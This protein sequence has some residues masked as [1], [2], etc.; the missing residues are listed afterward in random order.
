MTT[1]NQ[2]WTPEPWQI[3]ARNRQRIEDADGKSIA[4][5]A[6]TTSRS[7]SERHA[8]SARVC[9]CV[10]ALAGVANPQAIPAL[11]EAV[12]RDVS[13]GNASMAVQD[14]ITALDATPPE[15]AR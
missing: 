1:P 4:T 3:E 13:H 10:N 8:N 12:R 5:T 7:D 11:I 14:A 2:Q 15:T 6:Y 9:A